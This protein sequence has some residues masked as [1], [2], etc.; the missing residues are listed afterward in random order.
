MQIPAVQ[1]LCKYLLCKYST[2]QAASAATNSAET[3]F[4]LS[5][6]IL[7]FYPRVCPRPTCSQGLQKRAQCPLELEPRMVMSN[8]V[9]GVEHGSSAKSASALNCWAISP[10]LKLQNFNY[11]WHSDTRSQWITVLIT[12]E[13]ISC[14]K[15]IRTT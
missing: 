11:V 1:I 5:K 2:K 4:N 7:A 12:Y 14:T 8:H 6:C 13:I 3:I 15:M 9:L 10:A